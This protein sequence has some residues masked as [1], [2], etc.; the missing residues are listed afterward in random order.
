MRYGK[1]KSSEIE[2]QLRAAFSISGSMNHTAGM[3]N[4]PL[5]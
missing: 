2:K 5:Q 1:A 3:P 4:F